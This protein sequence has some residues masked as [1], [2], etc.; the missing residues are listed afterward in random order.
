MDPFLVLMSIKV[1]I[2]I[3]HDRRSLQSLYISLEKKKFAVPTRIRT[4][5]LPTYILPVELPRAPDARTATI[6]GF[7]CW[8][9]SAL[10][11]VSATCCLFQRNSLA[12]ALPK[13]TTRVWTR[14]NVSVTDSGNNEPGLH[15]TQEWGFD[16]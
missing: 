15:L 3:Q 16:P 7:E 11:T 4:S 9:F 10:W 8:A 14:P 6:F 2:G 1:T 12:R 13:R 5:R